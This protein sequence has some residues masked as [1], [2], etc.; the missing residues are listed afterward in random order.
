M[1]KPFTTKQKEAF[2]QLLRQGLWEKQEENNN[3][4]PLSA[5][6]WQTLYEMSI[7]Q[8]VQGIIYDGIRYLSPEHRPPRQLLLRWVAQIDIMER[9]NKQ[10]ISTQEIINQI[11]TTQPAI[12]YQ[13]L[14]G[15]GIAAHYPNPLHRHCGDIDLYFCG[16]EETEKAN[17]RIESLG[18]M[19][20]RGKGGE[21]SYILN[22][23]EIEHHSHLLDLNNPLL[24]KEQ[25]QWERERFATIDIIP[26]P[27]AN[28]LLISTH[29]LK[30]WIDLGIGLRQ[31]CDAAIMLKALHEQTDKE[32]LRHTLRKFNILSW[33]KLLYSLLNKHIGLPKEYLPFRCNANPDAMMEEIWESGNFGHGDTRY[34]KRPEGKWKSKMHTL[35]I[36]SNKLHI[37][38]RYATSETLWWLALLAYTRAKEICR[39]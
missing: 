34:G 19:V 11:F 39:H 17:R 30:H 21:S 36:V 20:T 3:I 16:D 15:Q 37:S 5:E 29:I 22:N 27:I 31:L 35:K 33:S 38:L 13:I 25:K 10:Q 4:F 14:K 1:K 2:M 28:H 12:K 6:E 32:E 9:R 8:T 23:V 24:K 7:V 18:I 26:T